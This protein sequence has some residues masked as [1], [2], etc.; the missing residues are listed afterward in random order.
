MFATRALNNITEK[1]NDSIERL[2]TG[3]RINRAADDAA[4]LA[5]SERMTAQVR[6]MNQATRNIND[7]VSML[8]TAEGALAEVTSLLQRA[9]ELAVQAANGTNGTTE[10]AA[11][12]AEYIQILDEITRIA[13]TTAFNGQKL[14]SGTGGAGGG[15]VDYDHLNLTDGLRNSWLR[16]GERLVSTYYGLTADNVDLEVVF[17]DT[18]QSYLAAVSG[19]G[20]G[21]GKLNNLQLHIDVDDFLPADA[22]AD[23][24]NAPFY[25]DRVIAHEMVHAVMARTTNFTA[26]ETWFVEG[27]AEFIHGADERLAA[28]IAANGGGGVGIGAVITAIGLPWGGN[29]IDYSSAYAAVRYMHDEIKNAGGN[30]IIDIMNYLNANQAAD[31]DNAITNASSGAFSDLANFIAS[32]TAV[33]GIAFVTAMDLSNA[34]T[35]AI[36][37]FDADAG[38]VRS[39]TD[40]LPNPQNYSEQPLT[41]FNVIWEEQQLGAGSDNVT[42]HVGP[43]AENTLDVQIRGLSIAALGLS[44]TSLVDDPYAVISRL[45]P[46]IDQISSQRAD[47]GAAMN[48]LEHTMNALQVTSENTQAARSRIQDTDYASEVAAQTRAQ[49]IQQSAM[50]MV[51]QANTFASQVLS[52]LN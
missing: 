46:A 22:S 16:E 50:A 2:A 37:G 28:D 49:I 43:D 4:G 18:A 5:I 13:D 15:N 26:L 27:T 23:G 44:S 40:V 6:G 10:R 11:L 39:A 36:G 35:G 47:L 30:G 29:S 3:K 38:A 1:N 32:Y 41:G 45:D 48:R 17:E 42:L 52:L 7:G 8:Q 12:N 9:R 34:D 51:S 21:S 14:L 19:S 25:N 31:L 20:D 24:G 33:G